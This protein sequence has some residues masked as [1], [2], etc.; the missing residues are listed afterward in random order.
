MFFVYVPFSP[1]HILRY[2]SFKK[3]YKNMFGW[4]YRDAVFLVDAKNVAYYHSVKS[5]LKSR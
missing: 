4:T 2:S 3:K 5:Y 1:V